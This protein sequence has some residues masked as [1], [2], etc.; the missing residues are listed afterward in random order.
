MGPASQSGH[1]VRFGPYVVDFHTRELRKNGRPVRLQEQSLKAL[2][3]LLREPGEI[4]TREALRRE[5]WPDGTTVDFDNGL[6]AAIGR[7]RQALCDS[8]ARPMYIE[9]VARTGYRWVAPLESVPTAAPVATT[10]PRRWRPGATGL[11]LFVIAAAAGVFWFLERG[12]VPKEPQVLLVLRLLDLSNG[13]VDQY[14]ADGI[15]EELTTYL[16]RVDPRHMNVIARSASDQDR[17]GGESAGAMARRLHA[18]YIL[19]GSIRRGQGRVRV[20]VQ[21][22]HAADQTHVWAGNYDLQPGDTLAM[23]TE[24]AGALAYRIHTAVNDAG[25]T[26]RGKPVTPAAYDACLKGQFYLWSSEITARSQAMAA[27]AFREALSADPEYAP[28]YAGLAEVNAGERATGEIA[29]QQDATEAKAYAQRALRLDPNLAEGH[30]ALGWADLIFDHDWTGARREFEKAIQ[31]DPN[32][33]HARALDAIYLLAVGRTEQAVDEIRLGLEMDPSSIVLRTQADRTFFL[34]RHYQEAAAECQKRLDVNPSANSA[35]ERL[36]ETDVFLNRCDEALAEVRRLEESGAR[37]SDANAYVYA[38]CG[39]TAEARRMVEEKER[40]YRPD[41][42]ASYEIAILHA[43]LGENGQ[44][45]DWLAR[46]YDSRNP[47]LWLR[48]K[49]DPRLDSVRLEPRFTELLH[50][51]QLPN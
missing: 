40:S 23:E 26:N 8:A 51:M 4:V 35:R 20:T 22:I 13:R 49:T 31:I 11:W 46:A 12:E 30:L 38:R 14:L 33:T 39:R 24:I 7:L 27:A 48:I 25:K 6:N 36:A 9:T 44:A 3:A 1:P 47:Y 29:G 42:L 41:S 43:A 15:T 50:R 5:L 28:A 45:M 10:V 19:E 16:A 17:S 32:A 34:S 2:I 37:Q 18:E 21:L